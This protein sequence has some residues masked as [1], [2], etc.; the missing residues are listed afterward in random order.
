MKSIGVFQSWGIGDLLMTVPVLSELRRVFPKA[1]I[2][3]FVG[4]SAQSELL[5]GSP[6]VD[7]IVTAPPS[8]PRR[9]LVK[10]FWSLRRYRFDAVY[11]GTRITPKVAARLR[12]I[13]GVRTIVGDGAQRSWLY[14][15]HNRIDPTVHRVDRMLETLALWT[16]QTPKQPVFNLPVDADTRRRAE[17]LLESE[18]LAANRFV[19]IHPGSGRGAGIQKRIPVHFAKSTIAALRAI[20]PEMRCVLLFGPDDQD[21]LRQ[22]MPPEPGVSIISNIS[23]N[24]TKVVLSRACGFIGSDSAL[25]HIAAAYGVPTITIAGPTNPDETRPYGDRARVVRSHEDLPCRPFWF[26]PLHGRC[27]YQLRCMTQIRPEQ[28][29]EAVAAWQP[30]ASGCGRSR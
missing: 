8:K 11:V 25:G 20:N 16:G 14:R 15:H 12:F 10:F 22:F 9:N 30:V 18:N 6:L 23:L 7:E 29:M 27:P 2:V 13:S 24:E 4:G 21:M 3:L 1:R 19:V 17:S 5:A 28:I 26:T